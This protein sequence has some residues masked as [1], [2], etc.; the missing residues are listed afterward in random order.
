MGGIR[1]ATFN[2]GINRGE[3]TPKGISRPQGNTFNGDIEYIWMVAVAL[4]LIEALK[5]VQ[6]HQE[7]ATDLRVTHL[8]GIQKISG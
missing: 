2:S 1:G 7:V 8:M 5:E 4:H 3:V 6:V